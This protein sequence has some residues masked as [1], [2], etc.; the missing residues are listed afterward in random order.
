M[1]SAHGKGA[2]DG[3]G[4]NLKRNAAKYNLQC[5]N[6]D[7]I[8]YATAL[9]HWAKNYCNETKIV[10]SSKEDHKETLKTLK[11]GFDAAVTIDGTAAYMLSIPLVDE[12]QIK[13]VFCI[14]SMRF[15]S[16]AKREASSEISS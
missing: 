3:I 14:Y 13:K 4:V 2:C 10:F 5:S 11:S 15:L 7:R 1:S 8:L 9:F 6:Q 16:K 12:T